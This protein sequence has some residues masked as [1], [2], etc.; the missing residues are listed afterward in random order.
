MAPT[1]APDLVGVCFKPTGKIYY[2][3]AGDLALKPGELVVA[4][5]SKGQ[6]L[7]EVVSEGAFSGRPPDGAD[8]KPILRRATPEDVQRNRENERRAHE[9][10]RVCQRLLKQ[11]DLPVKLVD[12]E[13]AFDGSRITFAFACEDRL[14]FRQLQR[15]LRE[16]YECEIDVRQIG[17]R[18][19]AKILGGLGPCGRHLCCA[20]FLRSFQPVTIRMAKDQDLS[21]NPT[22]ISG[23]CGRLMCCLRY[24]HQVY[25]EE[26][27]KL[28]PVGAV[29]ETKSYGTAEV[30]GLDVL[31]HQLVITTPEGPVH[32]DPGE[33]TRVVAAKRQAAAPPAGET[34]AEGPPCQRGVCPAHAE[35][36]AAAKAPEASGEGEAPRRKRRRR[37]RR[38]R[39]GRA[40]AE[41][42]PAPPPPAAEAPS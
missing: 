19:Q 2:F 38:S 30:S 8:L 14:D 40:A 20:S 7:A 21:L 15:E 9:A 42:T 23:L 31:R 36:P 37:S 13:F 18:D 10:R 12:V 27:D 1:D 39:R 33:V 32:I 5:T 11:L 22:K 34:L 4:E 25:R 6:E 28:P 35:A 41:G 26:R 24:E 29:I 17:V 3:A 16:I